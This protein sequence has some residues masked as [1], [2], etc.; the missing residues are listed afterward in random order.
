MTMKRIAIGISCCVQT[1]LSVLR[2][3]WLFGHSNARGFPMKR[4][5]SIKLDYVL[6]EVNRLGVK[7]TGTLM[8]LS[9][10]GLAFDYCSL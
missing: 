8:P 5:I 9:L 10:H 7:T 2:R 1:Y 4:L 6:M 3:S